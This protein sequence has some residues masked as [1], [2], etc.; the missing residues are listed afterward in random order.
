LATTHTHTH[1]HSTYIHTVHKYIHTYSHTYIHTYINT[2]STY[3]HT[4]THT[5]NTYIHTHTHMHTHIHTHTCAHKPVIVCLK[6]G[7]RKSYD[8]IL[9]TICFI[10]PPAGLKLF[11]FS[12]LK[13]SK[14]QVIS[15]AA[16]QLHA[17]YHFYLLHSSIIICLLDNA[18]F[19]DLVYV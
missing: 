9:C 17:L 7:R 10:L 6:E 1:T 3:K 8:Y 16:N 18:H 14:V 12:S 2:Y 4:Q 11:F 5:H 13:V 15:S 19:H